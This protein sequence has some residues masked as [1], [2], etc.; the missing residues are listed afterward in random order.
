MEN[1]VDYEKFMIK[2]L[3]TDA[4]AREKIYP[5]LKPDIFDGDFGHTEIISKFIEFRETYNTFPSIRD[6]RNFIQIKD[7]Y[8]KFDEIVG[9]D[10]SDITPE[11]LQLEAQEFF[12]KKL[13]MKTALRIVETIRSKGA[14]H[15][16]D[17]PDE[18]RDA[19]AFSFDDRVGMDLF[20]DAERMYNSMH[21]EDMVVSTGLKNLDKL[22]KNGFHKKTL[23]LLTAGANVG[24]SLF[25]CAL[26]SNALLQNKN[27]LYVT[28][29]MSEEKISERIL[30]NIFNYPINDLPNLSREQLG[31]MV[32]EMKTKVGGR[33]FVKEYPPH[34]ASA[35]TIRNLLKELS[36]KKKFKPD[37][38][39][40]D[41]VGIVTTNSK[42]VDGNTY[43]IYKRVTEELR[44]LAV[45]YDVPIVSSNQLN[46]AAMMSSDVDMSD[47]S[48]SIGQAMTAD[49]IFGVVQTEEMK[50]KNI[51]MLK[52]LKNRYGDKFNRIIF[53][54]DYRFMRIFE[55]EDDQ[56]TNNDGNFKLKDKQT[57]TQDTTFTPYKK[58]ADFSAIS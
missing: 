12:Q 38:I 53:G 31:K 2:L 58:D 6:F 49:I 17:V 35:N 3:F 44:G 16:S 1:I 21:E 36:I 29:E 41:Y 27:V 45:E 18:L 50:E 39:F 14:D 47:M 7:L 9:R 42:F 10:Y 8:E 13:V 51:Y 52:V 19:I 33:I 34:G 26:A 43:L 25:K 28:L 11:F 55:M 15:I 57:T 32:T 40:I 30:A 54:V 37:I 46:R 4:S 5:V 24:K 56:Y 20:D 48:D 22:I 23:T